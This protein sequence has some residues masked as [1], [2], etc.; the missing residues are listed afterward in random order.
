MN[1]PIFQS[2]NQLHLPNGDMAIVKFVPLVLKFLIVT[3]AFKYYCII[4]LLMLMVMC[5]LRC[6]FIKNRLILGTIHTNG[7]MGD[8]LIVY[9]LF[10]VLSYSL[11]RVVRA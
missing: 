5:G 11:L 8:Q 10:F 6:V 7:K 3:Y 1:Y 9:T 2:S 4:T